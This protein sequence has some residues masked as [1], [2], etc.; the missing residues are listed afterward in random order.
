MKTFLLLI[1]VLIIACTEPTQPST[2][3]T[4]STTAI[5]QKDTVQVKSAAEEAATFTKTLTTDTA[6]PFLYEYEKQH[7]ERYVRIITDYGNIDIELFNETPYHRANFIFLTKQKYF[8]GTVFHRVV[9]NFVIQGGNS[10]TVFSCCFTCYVV[11]RNF[12]EAFVQFVLL[13]FRRCPV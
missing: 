2:Q 7:K 3:T 8:D 4:K 12:A 6:I 5:I 13:F 1:S 9:K 10:V 11:S